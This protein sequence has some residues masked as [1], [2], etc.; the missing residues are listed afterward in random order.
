MSLFYRVVPNHYSKSYHRWV[1]RRSRLHTQRTILCHQ[2][3]SY[4]ILDQPSPKYSLPCFVDLSGMLRRTPEGFRPHFPSRG[5]IHR[6]RKASPTSACQRFP[7]RKHL[8]TSQNR[9]QRPGC[10]AHSAQVLMNQQSEAIWMSKQSCSRGRLHCQ[11]TTSLHMD[12]FSSSRTSGLYDPYEILPK[13]GYFPVSARTCNP[14]R[15]I[16]C[17]P[18]RQHRD[19]IRYRGRTNGGRLDSGNCEHS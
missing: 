4:V 6:R 11:E 14:F 19:H 10:N 5:H 7:R 8:D 15:E 2:D 18:R 3:V 12:S 13:Q 16:L 1:C 9:H 17:L